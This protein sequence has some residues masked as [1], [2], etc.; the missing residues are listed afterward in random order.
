M[1]S[2][3]Y[4]TTTAQSLINHDL[5]LSDKAVNIKAMNQHCRYNMGTI[6]HAYARTQE[7]NGT[8]LQYQ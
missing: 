7:R 4:L 1:K 6:H 3:G 2:I 8:R 5:A